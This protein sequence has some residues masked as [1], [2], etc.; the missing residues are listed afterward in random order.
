MNIYGYQPNEEKW[1]KT[2]I[3]KKFL[4]R[5]AVEFGQR[6]FTNQD[7]Y[8]IY[9]DEHSKDFKLPDD[10]PEI[11]KE[12]Q[13]KYSTYWPEMS[14]RNYLCAAAFRGLLVRVRPGVYMFNK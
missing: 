2:R 11:L 5:L 10:A 12:H 3:N 4:D 13:R 7:A 9:L 6:E 14:V 1:A 8:K